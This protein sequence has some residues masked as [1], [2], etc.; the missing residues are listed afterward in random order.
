MTG[1]VLHASAAAVW[2]KCAGHASLAART[3][4]I[5]D[6]SDESR[7]EGIEAHAV[8][9]AY[10]AAGEPPGDW[11]P[12]MLEGG[13][14]WRDVL[15]GWGCEYSQEVEYK[16]VPWIAENVPARVDA[17][18]YNAETN[19][20]H[21]ADYKYGH[22]YVDAYE[23]WQLLCYAMAWLDRHA[24]SHAHLIPDM[25]LALHIVQPRAGGHR[26]WNLTV[27]HL[28]DN[29]ARTI[30]EAARTANQAHVAPDALGFEL[31]TTGSHCYKCAGAIN[32]PA[33]RDAAS[34]A[35][36]FGSRNIE[37]DL[38][39][40]QAAIELMLIDEASTHIKNRR[41]ALEMQ[42]MHTLQGGQSLPHWSI[43]HGRGSKRWIPEKEAGL[44]AMGEL[45]GVE[46]TTEKLKS[47]TQCAKLLPAYIIDSHSE[48]TQG[49]ARIQ[50][51]RADDGAKLF[52][53][54]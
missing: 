8:A 44:K 45:Y 36:E 11:D 6:Q 48:V 7:L 31:Y 30:V 49:A 12:D 50:R 20:L 35:L 53:Q 19:T 25:K 43:G 26:T 4:R 18:G 28:R 47:P 54:E 38:T 13:K 52:T 42:V 40:E 21:V 27:Q 1:I 23:N 34:A 41:E 46:V 22:R 15:Q 37:L 24:K 3:P 9:Q 32:C 51:K 14:L 2:V 10:A 29:Y 16:C 17:E 39:P 5:A 33:L